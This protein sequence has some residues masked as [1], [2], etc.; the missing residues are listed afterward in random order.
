MPELLT[1]VVPLTLWNVAE[2]SPYLHKSPFLQA[3]QIE[4]RVK[5]EQRRIR[6]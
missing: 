1:N 6:Q 5:C 3:Q 4:Q 2:K